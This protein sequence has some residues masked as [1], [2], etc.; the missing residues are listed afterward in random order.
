MKY[1]LTFDD[2]TIET[3]ISTDKPN[4]T[5]QINHR[6]ATTGNYLG[7]ITMDDKVFRIYVAKENGRVVSSSFFFGV[8]DVDKSLQC[9]VRNLMGGYGEQCC[10]IY[11]NGVAH[12]LGDLVE[13]K[14]D[15]YPDSDITVGDILNSPKLMKKYKKTLPRVISVFVP[16]T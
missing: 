14:L 12:N 13:W 7:D 16:F 6:R 4:K 15:N 8:G 3:T 1:R 11:A 2:G 5:E 10:K 9:F